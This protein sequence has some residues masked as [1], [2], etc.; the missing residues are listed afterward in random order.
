MAPK[1]AGLCDI[2]LE[3]FQEEI[4]QIPVRDNLGLGYPITGQRV[5]P[6]IY[7][8]LST[9]NVVGLALNFEK[10][11]T[12]LNKT[13]SQFHFSSNLFVPEPA[14]GQHNRCAARAG[15]TALTTRLPVGAPYLATIQWSGGGRA[16]KQLRSAHLL[17][18]HPSVCTPSPYLSVERRDCPRTSGTFRT[19]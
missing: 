12:L 9:Q 10:K 11:T 19:L 4:S 18:N 15:P 7:W 14:E 1:P 17:H 2:S 13:I 8:V 16:V 6:M 5:K 3:G